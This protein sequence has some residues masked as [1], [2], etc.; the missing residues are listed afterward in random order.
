M[1]DITELKE[2]AVREVVLAHLKKVFEA[3]IATSSLPEE[4]EIL[5]ELLKI[6]EE[7]YTENQ[8]IV[9]Y[10]IPHYKKGE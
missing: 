1:R 3:D 6:V 8:D 2:C 7:K 10:W 9:R 4:K 5:S